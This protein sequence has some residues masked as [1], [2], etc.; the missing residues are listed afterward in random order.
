[1]VNSHLAPRKWGNVLLVLGGCL[2]VAVLL[3]SLTRKDEPVDG[4]ESPLE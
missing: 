1:M 2:F 3:P 4:L